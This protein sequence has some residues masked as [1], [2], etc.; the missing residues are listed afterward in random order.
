MFPYFSQ[1]VDWK[2]RGSKSKR[3]II[4]FSARRKDGLK[5]DFR[6]WESLLLVGAD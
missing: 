2:G 6:Q 1:S 4:E 5:G 3:R